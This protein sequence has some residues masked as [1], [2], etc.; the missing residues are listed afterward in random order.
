MATSPHGAA[1][2]VGERALRLAVVGMS[3]SATCGVRDHAGLLADAL[4]RENVEAALHWLRR[5]EQSLPTARAEVRAWTRRLALELERS[6]PDAVLLHYSVFSYSYRGIPLFVHPVLAVLNSAR[7][8]LVAMMHELVYPWMY[9]GWRGNVWALTQR[10]LLIDIMRSSSGAVVT[11]DSRAE[12]L[13]SRQ[14]LPKRRV[15]VAPVFSNLPPPAAV[16]LRDRPGRVI[17]LFGYS[18]QGAAVSLVLDAIRL[19]KSQGSDVQLRL[20]GAP[21]RSSPTGEAWLAAARTRT[22]TS[23]LS[24]SEALPAQAL[25]NALA[26]CDVLLFGDAAGPSSRKGTLAASLASGRPVVALDGRNRWPKLLDAE[27]ACVVLP[28]PQA[29]ADAI[30]ALLADEDRG[31]ALGARGRS[32][33]E[34]E[35]GVAR[36]AEAVTTLLDGLLGGRRS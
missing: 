17:G 5:D 7:V 28:T 19:L 23:A 3:V 18:Y 2:A 31:E 4:A 25:S 21:G 34:R 12:W 32:F 14:W 13:A 26:S 9:A 24:F 15:L 30:G 11:A 35:M 6:R 8:P 22:L 10:A 29:L 36:S 1:E 33:A 16:A 20:L 27:A